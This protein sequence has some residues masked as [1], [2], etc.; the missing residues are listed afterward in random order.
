MS[1]RLLSLYKSLHTLENPHDWKDD[2][3]ARIC[4]GVVKKIEQGLGGIYSTRRLHVLREKLQGKTTEELFSLRACKGIIFLDHP[5]KLNLIT[6]SLLQILG[7]IIP[8][9][10]LLFPGSV[11]MGTHSAVVP[12]AATRLLACDFRAP[13]ALPPY[14]RLRSTGTCT[15]QPARQLQRPSMQ[16]KAHT[17]G[18]PSSWLC[19]Q[20]APVLRL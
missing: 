1:K 12:I 11:R 7:K 10:Q 6:E 5:P 18:V 2:V 15:Q 17:K 14:R 8:I 13:R 16:W 3:G 20:A 4:H 19:S 9:H